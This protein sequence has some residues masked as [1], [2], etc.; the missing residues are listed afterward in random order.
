MVG[1]NLKL[2]LDWRWHG[3]LGV[4]GGLCI[5]SAGFIFIVI[6][7]SRIRFELLNGV[8]GNQRF[9]LH[10]KVAKEK[11]FQR[12]SQGRRRKRGRKGKVMSEDNVINK[13][14]T[15]KRATKIKT[16]RARGVRQKLK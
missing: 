12:K 3:A 5:R 16:T 15:D 9:N 6:T 8:W 10:Q 13:Q 1:L 4:R 2:F 7:L 11:D 14:A